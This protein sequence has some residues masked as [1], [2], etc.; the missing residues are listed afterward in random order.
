MGDDLAGIAKRAVEAALAGG[1]GDA[2]AYAQDSVGREIRIFDGQVESLTEAGERG[3]GV[4]CWIDHRAGYA[5]G[6]ELSDEG[7]GGI[8]RDAVETARIADAD[9]FAAPPSADG[10]ASPREI[11]GLNDPALAGWSTERKVELAKG[12]ER[13]AREA[14]ERVVGVETAV[15]ADEEQRVAIASSTGTRR[16]LRGDDRLRLPPGDRRGRR[17]QA[18]GPRLRHGPLAREPGPRRDRPRGG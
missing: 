2:E 7:I 18:D 10:G 15:Y 6:T 13:A 16:R 4:R 11:P 1:A 14:D 3:V 17:R 12:I 5:Y 9:E 8:A